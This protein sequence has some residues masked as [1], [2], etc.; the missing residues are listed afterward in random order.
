MHGR[1]VYRPSDAAGAGRV[2][3][4]A[5]G[6]RSVRFGMVAHQSGMGPSDKDHQQ[7]LPQNGQAGDSVAVLKDWRTQSSGGGLV[8]AGVSLFTVQKLMTHSTAEMTEV[9]PQLS[10]DHLRQAVELSG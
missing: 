3:H 10:D 5:A 6:G 9:Y 4:R 1:P 8:M 2:A 7:N